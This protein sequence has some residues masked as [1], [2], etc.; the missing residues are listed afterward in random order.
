[1]ITLKACF[2]VFQFLINI[3]AKK[4]H[5]GKVNYLIEEFGW[6]IFP[7]LITLLMYFFIQEF[8][9]PEQNRAYISNSDKRCGNGE[10]GY[11]LAQFTL[12]PLLALIFQIICDY[13]RTHIEPN[14]SLESNP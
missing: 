2:F 14:G 3:S 7:L 5:W 10:I 8:D 6:L 13:I 12:F 9:I 1:M 4:Y 11:M